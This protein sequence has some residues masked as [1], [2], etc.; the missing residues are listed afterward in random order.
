MLDMGDF[1]GG[2]LK[3]LARHPVERMTIAGGFGKLTKLSQGALDLHSSRSQVDFV[4][5]AET[6][7]RIGADAAA[8]R[9]ANTAMQALEIA[10]PKLAA[11]T[12]KGARKTALQALGKAPVSVDVLVVA[13]DGT[14]LAKASADG[15]HVLIAEPVR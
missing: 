4:R 14:A 13:R 6:A 2:L 15:A 10:G 7:E 8:V 3:Y 11:E 5:L 12:A 9:A 1:V